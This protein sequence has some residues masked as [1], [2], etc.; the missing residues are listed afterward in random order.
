MQI[1]QERPGE[2]FEGEDTGAHVGMVVITDKNESTSSQGVSSL[3][4]SRDMC[5]RISSTLCGR[6]STV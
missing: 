2:V 4:S 5:T 6:M 1:V 3:I